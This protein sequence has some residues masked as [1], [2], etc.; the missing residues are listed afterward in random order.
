MK[1]LLVIII[2]LGIAIISTWQNN[3]KKERRDYCIRQIEKNIAP[4]VD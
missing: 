2:I 1:K 3:D 4:Y